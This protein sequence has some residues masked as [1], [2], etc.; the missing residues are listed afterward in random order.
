VRDAGSAAPLSGAVVSA[1]DSLQK[2]LTRGISDES[3]RYTLDLIQG[4]ASVRIVRIG[5][6][7]RTIA[8]SRGA[9][10]SSMDIEMTRLA[11]LLS[12][13]ARQR[14]SHLFCG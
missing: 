9:L 2:P 10:A 7:P 12:G 5:Y 13:P 4:A 14:P 8:L 11:T 3:G 1:V 6:Q